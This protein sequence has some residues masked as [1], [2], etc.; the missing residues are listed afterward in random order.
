M[1]TVTEFMSTIPEERLAAVKKLRSVI[2]KNLPDGFK[3]RIATMVHYEVPLTTY[4]DGYH[5]KPDTPLP[6]IS[7]ANQKNNI[8]IYH[9]GVYAMPELLEWFQ[10]AYAA[11]AKYKLNMGKSCIR[12]KRMDDIPFDVIGELCSKITVEDWI[13]HY[14]KALKR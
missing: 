1:A 6:F 5:C 8:S 7:L 10:A 3:E 9:M 13:A 2:K 11:Q 4:P 12:L 14:E